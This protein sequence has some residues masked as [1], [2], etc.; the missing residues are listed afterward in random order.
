MKNCKKCHIPDVN[1]FNICS[2]YYEYYMENTAFNTLSI[3]QVL[4]FSI[5]PSL[6]LKISS[7]LCLVNIFDHLL[8]RGDKG[9]KNRRGKYKYVNMMKTRKAFQMK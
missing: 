1:F 2:E 6:L 3:E 5:R 9:K 8:L 4:S 7:N